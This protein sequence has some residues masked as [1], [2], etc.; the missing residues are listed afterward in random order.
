MNIIKEKLLL[1]MEMKE[2]KLEYFL[3]AQRHR[4]S[5]YDDAQVII[6]DQEVFFEMPTLTDTEVR[7]KAVEQMRERQKNVRAEAAVKI[8]ELDEKIQKLM[9]LE[10]KPESEGPF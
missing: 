5:L 6:G 3:I 9:L 4:W 8:A 10:H 2:G 1:C 7:L